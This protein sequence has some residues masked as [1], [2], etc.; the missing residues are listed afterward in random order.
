M[1]SRAFKTRF[2]RKGDSKRA[3][4]ATPKASRRFRKKVSKQ[5][6]RTTFRASIAFK[7]RLGEKTFNMKVWETTLKASNNFMKKLIRRGNQHRHAKA[8]RN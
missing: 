2:V 3:G 5:T 6:G 4:V 8:A 7:T 1:V